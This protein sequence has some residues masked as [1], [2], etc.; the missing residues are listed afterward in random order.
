MRAMRTLM[1]VT[2]I[3]A[4]QW[5]KD[6]ELMQNAKCGVC[7]G[8]CSWGNHR[9]NRYRFELYIVNVTKTSDELKKEYEFAKDIARIN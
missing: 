5:M 8:K 1:M 3:V 2:N 6:G 4:L 7:I 9:N